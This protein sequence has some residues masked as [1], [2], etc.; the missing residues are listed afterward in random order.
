MNLRFFLVGKCLLLVLLLW[1]MPLSAQHKRSYEGPGNW[2][3]SMDVGTSLSLAENVT[4][5]DFLTTEIPSGS[6]SFGRVFSPWFGMRLSAGFYSQLGHA[7]KVAVMYEPETYTPY[8]FHTGLGTLEAMLNLTNLSRR[9]D[10]RNWFDCYLIAG[11]GALYS[12][13]F[14]KKVDAWYV[15][16]Y[17]VSSEELLTWVGKG[18]WLG[19]WH[20]SREWDLSFELDLLVTENAY[21]GV[22]DRLDRKM[23]FFLS[24]RLGMTYY[25]ENRKG[26]HRFANPAVEHRFWKN[27]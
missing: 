7:S 20:V 9:Y 10:V 16:V 14:D 1:P 8:R 4:Y 2:F 15:D 11:G 23:D 17:P 19:T 24:F 25:L 21:N 6:L 5:E 13:G 18:G 3:V 26:R 12:F 22:V 27:Q